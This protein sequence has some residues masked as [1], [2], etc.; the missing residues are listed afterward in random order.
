[1]RGGRSLSGSNENH[2]KQS[3][4]PLKNH[5]T[6]GK[7][8]NVHDQKSMEIKLLRTIACGSLKKRYEFFKKV[9]V[10]ET[11][12]KWDEVIGNVL[13]IEALDKWYPKVN[14]THQSIFK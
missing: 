12:G 13:N 3:V 8:L 5:K 14:I 11:L 7:L 6:S 4:K 2:G 10:K 9:L 1:M